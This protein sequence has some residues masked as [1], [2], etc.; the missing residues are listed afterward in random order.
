MIIKRY[1]SIIFFIF[2][3]IH[4]NCA[5]KITIEKI[6]VIT[7]IFPLYDFV[8]EIGKNKINV[9]MILPPGTESHSFEPTPQDILKIN[10]SAMFIYISETMEPW[11]R[12]I[13]KSLKNPKLIILEAGQNIETLE[14]SNN[15]SD[16]DKSLK[17]EHKKEN[18]NHKHTDRDP[19]IWL[20]FEI[21][22][23]IVINISEKLSLIDPANKEFYKKNAE[24]YN[25]KLAQL[26]KKYKETIDKCELKI[27]LYAG[28]FAFGYLVK[29]YGLGYLSPYSGFSPNVEP[30]PQKI[31]ELIDVIKKNKIEYLFYEELIN[32]KVAIAISNS[33]GVKLELLSAAHNLSKDELEKNITFLQIME[34]NLL[35]LKKALK[36]KEQK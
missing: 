16:A 34:T 24:E 2:L 33:T 30:T 3:L 22:Q 9:S 27:I 5:K 23:K 8:R 32:P 12:D 21:A 31:A 35:K 1:I 26:D 20:D 36:Y 15:H 14:T 13:I 6:N 29:R 7:S 4:I 25:I 28:H 11:A 19:H 17:K 18:E 10:E